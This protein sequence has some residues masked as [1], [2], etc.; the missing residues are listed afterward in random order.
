MDWFDKE[1]SEK[2]S[3][4]YNSHVRYQLIEL[5]KVR[6]IISLS[7][8]YGLLWGF[9]DGRIGSEIFVPFATMVFGYFFSKRD[10]SYSDV[11]DK[12]DKQ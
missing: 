5:F 3:Y 10:K 9:I 2:C 11:I 7:I 1:K 12:E 8:C 4:T 6:S